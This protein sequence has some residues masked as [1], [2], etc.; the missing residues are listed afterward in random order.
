M[1]RVVLLDC[2]TLGTIT[3]PNDDNAE[4]LHCR[5]WAEDLRR[6]GTQVKIPAIADYE[7]RREYIRLN[8]GKSLAELDNLVRV[9]GRVDLTP[10]ALLKA[11]ELWAAAKRDYGRDLRC[12]HKIDADMILC[13]QAFIESANGDKILIATDN[14]RHLRLAWPESHLWSDITP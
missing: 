6:K 10:E 14:L 4:G 3:N 8:F 12:N 13:G 5:Q 11:A 7:L 1:N 2:C 9:F